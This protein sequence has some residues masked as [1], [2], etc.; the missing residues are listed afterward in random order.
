ML[1]KMTTVGFY[2]AM[3]VEQVDFILKQT[4]MQTIVCT[5]N[6]AKKVLQ[7]KQQGLATMIKNLIV[8]DPTAGAIPADLEQLG[9]QT[10]ITLHTFAGVIEAG[11]G[12][13]APRIEAKPEDIH[14]LSYTSG[15]TGDS[16]GVKLSHKN[17]M[18]AAK[19]MGSTINLTI[20]EPVISYLP[21]THSFEQ[22]LFAY[23]I[24][25]GLRIGFYQGNPLKLVE[26]C[27][28]LKPCM[29][30]SVPRLY[31]KI[32]GALQARFDAVTGC[33]R[34]LLDRGLAAKQANLQTNGA[35]AHGCYD[36]L[37]FSKA[38]AMLGGRVR[39]MVTGSAPIDKQVIDFLKICFSVPILEGYGL[40]ESSA[41]GSIMSPDD[42]VTGHVGGPVQCSKF[43]LKSLPEMDYTIDDKPYPQGELLL[44]GVSM[45]T[46]YYKRQDLTDGAHDA[47]GW[48]K[49]GDVVRVFE[50]GSVKIIDRSKNIFKLSQGEYIA[51][52]KIENIFVLSP[53]I[54]QC[55]IYGDSLKNSCV[56]VIIPSEP[57]AKDWARENGVDGDFKTIIQNPNIKKA[58]EQEIQRL[59][60]ENKL[61]SL[62]KPKG[63]HLES[64]PFSVDNDCSTPTFKLKRHA[65]A[66]V[67]KQQID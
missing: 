32:F 20:G 30:P 16:K 39:V 66:K 34:W 45:F 53:A 44:K 1:F 48:F 67:Y 17:L 64:D 33:K 46:G 11:K 7:M 28:M 26:D 15:T 52:E 37:L 49:T 43:R 42:A 9:S 55:F 40:T 35:V 65:C 36:T 13:S 59:G 62:E 6:Y 21:Y 24:M 60:A 23:E 3:G 10:G 4:E 56:S 25:C 2:D 38:A 19:S 63:I 50:N 18:A 41:C 14:V 22:A 12:F 57:W 29:F 54:E 31:N 8:I 47:D 61:S 27:A 58:I 51:P 5:T